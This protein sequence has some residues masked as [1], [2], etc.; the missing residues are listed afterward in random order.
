MGFNYSYVA[1]TMP[2]ERFSDLLG[3]SLGPEVGYQ[4]DRG[5]WATT[6]A[7]SGYS[8]LTQ[9]DADYLGTNAAGLAAVSTEADVLG[10][11]VHEG[12]M[13]SAAFCWSG[14][15]EI[16]SVT[17]DGGQSDRKNLAITG[18][19]PPELEDIRASLFARQEAED[20]ARAPAK[21]STSNNVPAD[22]QRIADNIGATISAFDADGLSVDHVFD[23]PPDL[24]E[25]IIGYRYDQVLEHP[26]TRFWTLLQPETPKAPKSLINRL[27]QW[28][29]RP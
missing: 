14:G 8:V 10:V 28:K 12:V 29:G 27:F 3:F 25:A 23:A 1:S 20:A 15:R 16:W 6:I 9:W 26:D 19:P 21:S 17:H 5:G 11:S 13:H 4:P 24:V 18:A 2:L 7:A 22:L